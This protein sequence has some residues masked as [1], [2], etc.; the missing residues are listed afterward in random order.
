[1][2]H[3]LLVLAKLR[4]QSLLLRRQVPRNVHVE[5]D[6]LVSHEVRP[7][8]TQPLAPQ[9]HL[10]IALRSWRHVNIHRAAQCRHRDRSSQ[11][12]RRHRDRHRAV[13]IGSATAEIAVRLHLHRDV[14]IARAASVRAR[15]ALADET[16]GVSVVDARR[17]LHRDGRRGVLDAAAVTRRTHLRVD[18]AAAAAARTRRHR[19]HHASI[20]LRLTTTGET[21]VDHALALALRTRLMLVVRTLSVRGEK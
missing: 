8:R 6:D 1:M 16:D 4:N 7:H 3:A 21:Y 9:P 11:N 10:R 20:R 2:L 14:Q 5:R 19:H 17:D 12:R 18:G 13:H 15:V